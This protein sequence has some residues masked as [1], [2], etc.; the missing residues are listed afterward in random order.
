MSVLLQKYFD[1]DLSGLVTGLLQK[2]VITIW[3]LI[4][5]LTFSWVTQI[6]YILNLLYDE[7]LALTFTFLAN[8]SLQPSIQA[9]T[10]PWCCW[11]TL[12]QAASEGQCEG[13]PG[14]AVEEAG[15]LPQ[16]VAPNS[17]AQKAQNLVHPH[18]RSWCLIHLTHPDLKK[19]VDMKLR[20]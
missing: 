4:Y 5:V 6:S 19:P 20:K 18:M 14:W 16:G 8:S 13:A 9:W 17:H 2:Y 10:I 1:G 11:W 7:A 3:A 15:Q 12:C